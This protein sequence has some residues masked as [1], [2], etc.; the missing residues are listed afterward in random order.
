M[1]K[2]FDDSARDYHKFPVPGKLTVQ[3][4]KPIATQRDL[5]LAYSPGVAVPCEDIAA[6]PDKVY[7]YTSRG[8]LVAVISNG[9]AVLGLGNIGPLASKPV[10]EGKAVLF[11]KFAE[12]DA[13]DIEIDETDPE[14]FIETVARLEPSFGG[15]NL[16]DI[17]APE[18]FTIEQAL[19]KRMNIP[20]FHDDQHGTAIIVAAAALNWM[21]LTGRDAKTVKVVSAGA[22]AAAIACCNMLVEIGVKREHIMIT[23]RQGVVYKGRDDTGKYRGAFAQETRARTL[24]DAMEAFRPDLFLGLS[25]PNVLDPKCLKHMPAKPFVMA[26]ANPTP[27]IKPELV[28]EHRPDALIAT[29]RSDYPNQV[30]NVLCFPFLF[31]GALDV[32]ATEINEAVKVACVKALA[33]LTKRESQEEVSTAYNTESFEFGPEYLIP[34]ALDPRLAVELPLAVARAAMESGVARKPIK[35][36]EHYRR[37]LEARVYKTSLVMRPVFSLAKQERNRVIYAEGEDSR[38]LHALSAVID[39]GIAHPVLVAR[40]G[41]LE[42]RMKKIGLKLEENKDYTVVDPEDDPRYREYWM[43]YHNIMQRKG[44]SSEVARMVLHTN[45]TVIASLLLKKGEGDA[46]I[47]GTVGR[48]QDHLEDVTNIIGLKKGVEKPASMNLLVLPSGNYFLSDAYV[49]VDPSPEDLLSITKLAADQLSHF[50]ITPRVA[51]LSHSNF[52]SCNDT[53]S[54]KMRRALEL[55]RQEMPDLEVDGEMHADAALLSDIREKA[56]SDSPLKESAN[57]LIMPNMAAANI[58][59]NLIKTIT[60]GL[61]I[62]P[63]LMGTAQPVH[64]LTPSVRTRGVINVSALAAAAASQRD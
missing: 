15:I 26:L 64:I 36:F 45:T 5:S 10:M 55:I 51:L 19:R 7:D 25:G 24:E 42:S 13:I 34:K 12:I 28:K 46:M 44:V 35:D 60:E 47:C 18:C 43:S 53:S 14:K 61:S 31:R 27:E 58:A 23:D 4:S 49:N 6:D 41:V 3:A 29:G 54:Q 32:R 8:N 38:V 22:G 50:G 20:V 11:R 39:E 30:N 37:E 9:T 21:R 2:S 59:F 63:I 56:V 57:L 17:K 62:G 48:F 16:E 1:A 52:G 33:D 40:R